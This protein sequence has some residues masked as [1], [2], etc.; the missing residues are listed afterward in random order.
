[1]IY[2]FLAFIT[3]IT[4]LSAIMINGNLAREEGMINGIFINNLMATLSSIVLCIIMKHYIPSYS[5]VS[6]IPLPYFF[7]SILSVSTTYIFNLIVP[8]ISAFYIVILSFIGQLLASIVI[9]YIYLELF[10]WG[11]IIGVIL[12]FMGLM[13]NAKAD[14]KYQ[15]ED[16]ELIKG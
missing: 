9:D 15:Q 8:K 4:I 7:G 10:S 16:K 1:M 3:G 6:A 2:L 14:S 11:Q 5:A 13:I 12:F